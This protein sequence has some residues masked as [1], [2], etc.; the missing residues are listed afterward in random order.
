M[1]AWRRWT[2]EETWNF[3]W[4]GLNIADGADEAPCLHVHARRQCV[5]LD[6]IAARLDHVAHQ[7][8]EDVIRLVDF[9]DLDLQ[10][11]SDVAV[12]RCFSKLLRVYLDLQDIS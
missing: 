8:G 9:L 11:R 4:G 12:E 5:F 1:R 7:L 10:E 6:E 3:P 2:S